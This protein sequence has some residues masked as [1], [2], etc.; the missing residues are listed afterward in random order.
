MDIM[1]WGD[2]DDLMIEVEY[3]GVTLSVNVEHNE[4]T[5][6]ST[7]FRHISGQNVFQD[8]D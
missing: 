8:F 3:V 2:A 1:Q 7:V 6:R 4:N 5:L